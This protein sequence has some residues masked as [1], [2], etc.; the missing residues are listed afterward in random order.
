MPPSGFAFCAEVNGPQRPQSR[1]WM[2]AFQVCLLLAAAAMAFQCGGPAEDLKASSGQ[3][4]DISA[5]KNPPKAKLRILCLHGYHGSGAIMRG[6]LGPL[7]QG[8]DSIADFVYITAPS[9]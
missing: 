8:L 9:K 1:K 7:A 3:G 2:R 6:Q 4:Q 5:R